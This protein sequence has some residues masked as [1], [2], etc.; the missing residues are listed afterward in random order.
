[1]KNNQLTSMLVVLLLLSTLASVGLTIKYNFAFHKVQRLQP[2]LVAANNARNIVQ[3]LMNDSIEY[4]KTHPDL[5]PVL[6]PFIGGPKPGP[7]TAN[8]AKK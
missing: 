2:E 5:K 8:S 6:Q 4:S 7:V 1:M 3:A